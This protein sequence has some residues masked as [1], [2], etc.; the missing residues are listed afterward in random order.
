MFTLDE[1]DAHHIAALIEYGQILRQTSK[2][3][4][5]KF[6]R[7]CTLKFRSLCAL[8][9]LHEWKFLLVLCPCFKLP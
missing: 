4:R 1:R 2:L 7:K 6:C 9:I 3:P 8:A 5:G